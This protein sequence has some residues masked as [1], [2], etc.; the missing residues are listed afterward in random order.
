[1]L[2]AAIK[3]AFKVGKINFKQISFEIR[4]N[5]FI[6]S[7]YRARE[8]TKLCEN[9]GDIRWKLIWRLVIMTYLF[10]TVNLHTRI[11]FHPPLLPVK[12]WR[13]RSHFYF[14]MTTVTNQTNNRRN[15]RKHCP[16][17]DKRKWHAI[18]EFSSTR[19][20]SRFRF[21]FFFGTSTTCCFL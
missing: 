11:V 9:Y 18:I 5:P 2:K 7:N 13:W 14:A 6:K 16:V 1:L 20:I 3:R 10:D 15:N 12:R 17:I 19:V 21:F 4:R 8:N